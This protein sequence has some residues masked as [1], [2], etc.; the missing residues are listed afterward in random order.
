MVEKASKMN[1]GETVT[2]VFVD[3]AD[4]HTAT[5]AMHALQARPLHISLSFQVA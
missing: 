3:F 1:E 5:E 2:I 4:V